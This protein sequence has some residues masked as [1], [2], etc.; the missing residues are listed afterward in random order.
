VA[1]PF[2]LP[3][4]NT[5]CSIR[6]TGIQLQARKLFRYLHFAT[7]VAYVTSP[8]SPLRTD[9]DPMADPSRPSHKED[10]LF[11]LTQTSQFGYPNKSV[12]L[13]SLVKHFGA[14][15]PIS[16][17]PQNT[18]IHASIQDDGTQTEEVQ[19]KRTAFCE[20]TLQ[21]HRLIL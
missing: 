10:S 14:A 16:Q 5:S 8:C 17:Q 3:A 6:K 20:G 2:P 19:V 4:P 21:K 11:H 7:H 15:P 1:L 9:H 18:N 13:Y 12:D